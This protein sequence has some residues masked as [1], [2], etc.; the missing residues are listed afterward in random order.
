MKSKH[1]NVIILPSAKRRGLDQNSENGLRQDGMGVES[2]SVEG[3]LS[4]FDTLEISCHSFT[5]VVLSALES[6]KSQKYTSYISHSTNVC[7][8]NH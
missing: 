2:V 1:F 5:R 3:A 7:I 6:M 8:Q 4:H